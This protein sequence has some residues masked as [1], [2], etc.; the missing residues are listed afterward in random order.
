MVPHKVK[1]IIVLGAPME[2]ERVESP[3]SAQIEALHAEYVIAIRALFDRH[4]AKMGDEWVAA[5]GVK[6][7][8]EDEAPPKSGK[9]VD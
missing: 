4:K 5:R 1:M 2:V 6:L 3:T 9:K 8:L 7:Y